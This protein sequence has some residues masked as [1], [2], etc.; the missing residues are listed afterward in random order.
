M[1]KF[2]SITLLSSIS[3]LIPDPLSNPL[4]DLTSN[5]LSDLI[6]DPPSLSGKL[7]G[8]V[9]KADDE[10]C[11]ITL[12]KRYVIACHTTSNIPS[13]TFTPSHIPCNTP[14]PL[15]RC[16]STWTRPPPLPSPHPLLSYPLPYPLPYPRYTPY[17]SLLLISLTGMLKRAMARGG[18]A[19]FRKKINVMKEDA[20]MDATGG[21]YKTNC[22]C[23]SLL[24]LLLLLSSLLLSLHFDTMTKAL[25]FYYN[26]NTFFLIWQNHWYSPKIPLLIPIQIPT[27]ISHTKQRGPRRRVAPTLLSLAWGTKVSHWHTLSIHARLNTSSRCIF[28]IYPLNAPSFS[29]P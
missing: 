22:C 8:A 18:P 6:S 12:Q 2:S 24:P 5:S 14:L 1:W 4:S 10:N 3:N 25:P 9:G 23:P 21:S 17:Q 26:Q 29:A 20:L 19:R 28:S 16:Q 13:C 27:Q 15:T 7:Y 11:L